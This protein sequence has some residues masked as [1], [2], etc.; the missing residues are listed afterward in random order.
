MPAKI[1][2]AQDNLDI[3]DACFGNE[4]KQL[5]GSGITHGQ[6]SDGDT[7][8]VDHDI[9]AQMG[10]FFIAGMLPV[11]GSRVIDPQ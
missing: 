5:L 9:A 8:A 1:N 7:V 3:G 11:F 2:G 6:A 10:A 4:Y